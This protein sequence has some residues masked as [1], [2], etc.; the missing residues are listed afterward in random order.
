[1]KLHYMGKFN[2]DPES[3]ITHRTVKGATK[4]KEPEL[5]QYTSIANTIALILFFIMLGLLISLFPVA[6]ITDAF[7]PFWAILTGSLLSTIPHE[8]LHA[9]CFHNEVYMYT[10]L[11][12]GVLFVYGEEDFTKARYVLM[13]LLPNLIFG[14]I[15]FILFILH[16]QWRWLGLIGFIAVPCG[17]GDY[18]NVYNALTQ[19]PKDAKVFM[20]K[21]STYWYKPSV[22]EPETQTNK[23]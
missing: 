15:P 19:V 20:H 9:V 3:L 2:S 8:M 14:F 1:M 13:S 5:K 10:Y 6:H 22:N 23:E 7:E 12:R 18:I 17:A 4:F 11:S 16:P 21:T